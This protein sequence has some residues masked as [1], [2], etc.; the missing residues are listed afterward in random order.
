MPEVGLTRWALAPTA[1]FYDPDRCIRRSHA[2]D[3]REK[4]VQLCRLEQSSS[5]HGRA[6]LDGDMSTYTR[7]Q[8][9]RIPLAYQAA[10]SEGV[11]HLAGGHSA[12]HIGSVASRYIQRCCI[13]NLASKLSCVLYEH[14]Y[15]RQCQLYSNLDTICWE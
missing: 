2:A 7:H 3:C 11:P 9:L 10:T 4:Q 14:L 13:C 12:I 8:H 15:I 1:R 5:T 6:Q